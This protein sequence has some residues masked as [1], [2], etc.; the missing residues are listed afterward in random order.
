MPDGTLEVAA[1]HGVAYVDRIEDRKL[2]SF[3]PDAY[4]EALAQYCRAGFPR[5]MLL[6]QTFDA[7]LA[8]PRLAGRLGAGVVMNTVGIEV[9]NGDVRVTASAYGGDTRVVYALAGAPTYILSVNANAV[10]PQPGEAE[11]TGKSVAVFGLLLQDIFGSPSPNGAF[12]S[13]AA[14]PPG[15]DP[16]KLIATAERAMRQ[17]YPELDAERVTQELAGHTLVGADLNFIYLDL[18]NTCQIRCLRVPA[19]TYL[20]FTQAEDR[21]FA[22]VE[23]I[24]EA[25][26]VSFLRETVEA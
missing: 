18:T 21:E 15:A 9:E 24:F 19:A 11:P 20:V 5:L 22:Q 12:W 25:M 16:E 23:R 13:I 26:T 4:V 6:G 14:H 1:R 17:E 10:V 3:Q 7:R 2:Q 8:A